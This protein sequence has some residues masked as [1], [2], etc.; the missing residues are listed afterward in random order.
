MIPSLLILMGSP[1]VI[2]FGKELS[3]EDR[4]LSG[5]EISVYLGFTKDTVCKWPSE[6]DLPAYRIRRIYEFDEEDVDV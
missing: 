4:W 2:A 5:E 3:M 6:S 1:G